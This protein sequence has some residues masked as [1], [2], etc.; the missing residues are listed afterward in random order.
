MFGYITTLYNRLTR[1]NHLA[2]WQI[3]RLLTTCCADNPSHTMGKELLDQYELQPENAFEVL[4]KRGIVTFEQIKAVFKHYNYSYCP[5]HVF[6][7]LLKDSKDGQPDT[8]NWMRPITKYK[9]QLL[10]DTGYGP[11]REGQR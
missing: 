2:S 9:A 6:K 4:I 8:I 3:G 1:P 10:V 7:M 11:E 5:D